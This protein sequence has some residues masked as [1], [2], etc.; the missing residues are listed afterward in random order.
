MP[1]PFPGMNPYLEKSSVWHDFHERFLPLAAEA[2]GTQVLPGYVVKIDEHVH[3]HELAQESRRLVGRA[4]LLV[5]A[6][7]PAPG[8][9]AA[10]TQLFVLPAEVTAAHIDTESVSYLEIRDRETR[11]VVTVVEVLSPLN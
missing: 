8:A 10:G 2:L 7:G 9:P 11:Q 1:S 5:T 3:V 4:D 6:L